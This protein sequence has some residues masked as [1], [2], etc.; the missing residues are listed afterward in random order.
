MLG[1]PTPAAK[2]KAKA[3][4]DAKTGDAT[5]QKLRNE[6][7]QLDEL[8]AAT[9][10]PEHLA[11]AKAVAEKRL[12]EHI[13]NK[14]TDVPLCYT[15]VQVNRNLR[16][17]QAKLL[18]VEEALAELAKQQEAIEEKVKAEDDRKTALE[19]KIKGLTERVEKLKVPKAGL[20][21]DA[22]VLHL[23]NAFTAL[24]SSVPKDTP[25]EDDA[26]RTQSLNTIGL[27]ITK[28]LDDAKKQQTAAAVAKAE[29]EAMEVEFHDKGDAAFAA[30]SRAKG[31]GSGGQPTIKSGD[32]RDSD[33]V[34]INV[35]ESEEKI[36]EAL[37]A[38][39]FSQGDAEKQ[40][41]A[42][43]ELGKTM[44]EGLQVQVKRRRV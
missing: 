13:E 10:K 39:G 31:K 15:E 21:W 18:K 29:A 3:K 19:E 32:K 16:K 24:S 6:I 5:Q 14:Q 37:M 41:E 8:M 33:V 1:K 23:Q 38:S 9:D 4:A 44:D 36:R 30:G 7:K 43:V 26:E 42:L 25:A 34:S 12:A 40:A 17:E 27:H 28:A 20:G 35:K 22:A 2:A 11:A